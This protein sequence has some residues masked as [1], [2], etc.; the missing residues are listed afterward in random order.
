[1]S[2]SRGTNEGC[3]DGCHDGLLCLFFP[4]VTVGNAVGDTVGFTVALYVGDIGGKNKFIGDLDD[5]NEVDRVVGN[6]KGDLVVW[7]LGAAVGVAVGEYVV[8][9]TVGNDL[10]GSVVGEH[11][12]FFVEISSDAVTEGLKE[13]LTAGILDALPV[14]L[15]EGLPVGITDGETVGTKLEVADGTIAGGILTVGTDDVAL[16]GNGDGLLVRH[17]EG[18]VVGRLEGLVV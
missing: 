14:G 9:D 18:F 17:F 10:V 1:M 16:D 2:S 4:P 8:G 11:E 15:K 12:G 5:G 3:V 6:R 13:G 7:N